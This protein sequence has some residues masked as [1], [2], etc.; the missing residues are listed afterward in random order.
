MLSTRIADESDLRPLLHGLTPNP[1]NVNCS[2]AVSVM[3]RTTIVTLPISITQI[4]RFINSTTNRA[5]LLEGYHLSM[6]TI[7]TPFFAA[8][9]FQLL[10]KIGKPQIT[11]LTPPEGFHTL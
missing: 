3:H 4:Q 5:V 1:K 2:V 8:D 7:L 9:V 11:D 6:H 10:D